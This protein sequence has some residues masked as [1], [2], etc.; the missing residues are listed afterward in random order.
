MRPALRVAAT[1]FV[2]GLLL[3]A[4]TA[5]GLADNGGHGVRDVEVTVSDATLAPGESA[6]LTTVA[7][8][9]N[10]RSGSVEA[11]YTSSD[12][13][14]LRVRGGRLEAVAPGSATVTAVAGRQSDTVD[15]VVQ[16][17]ASVAF[18]LVRT[19]RY[20]IS[21]VYTVSGAGFTPGAEVTV[22]LTDPRV[23]LLGTTTTVAPD[24]TFTGRIDYA[25][26]GTS[27][28]ATGPVFSTGCGN[29][30]LPPSP[31]FPVTLQAVDTAGVTAT[32]ASQLQC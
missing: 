13:S 6:A 29:P 23:Q 12:P 4:G 16:Q 7:R 19:D 25:E 1:A 24:G 9:A 8:Y 2:T 28:T 26:Y 14:V 27:F 18:T 20:L 10:G 5:P 21:R 17:P 22:S 30:Y 15:V 3:G 11:T 32:L 31:P